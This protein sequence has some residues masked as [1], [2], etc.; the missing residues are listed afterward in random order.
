MFQDKKDKKKHEKE[1]M[2]DKA[3][4]DLKGEI[5]D[6]ESKCLDLENKY[7]RALAD[8]QN[9]L[10]R[11]AEEKREF[12]RFANEGMI[13]DFLPVSE[14]LKLAVNHSSGDQKE[15]SWLEGVKYVIKQFGDIMKDYGV[16]EIKTVGEKYDHNL[17]EALENEKTED[18]EKEGIVA[19]ELSPG[20]TMNGKVIKAARVI[21]Y[22][23]ER[24]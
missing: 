19:R 23:V 1:V 6:C 7:K 10:K 17:M 24:N 21:V 14:N 20:Y 12:V 13:L 4:K 11:S 18:E 16:E 22:E 8:Y 9:L 15:N 2:T 5:G 3:Q